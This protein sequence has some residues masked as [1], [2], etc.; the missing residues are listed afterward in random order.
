[1][2]G[3]S[4]SI[5]RWLEQKRRRERVSA[6]VLAVLALSFG[7][8]VF[9]LMTFVI[10]TI[11]SIFSATLVHSVPWLALASFAITAGFFAHFLKHKQDYL[12]LSL[13]PLGIWI[14][15]DISSIGPRLIL[16][17]L[18]QIRC[19]GFLGELNVGACAGHWL[20]WRDTTRR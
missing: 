3:V 17:G 20:T 8:A 7:A 5:V 9:L 13:D 1:M 4:Q 15:K 6:A 12:D 14:I 10:Y 11:L 19:C 18:R 2:H 16:E